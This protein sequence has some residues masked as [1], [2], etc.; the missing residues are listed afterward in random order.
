M[1]P[2]FDRIV[3]EVLALPPEARAVLMDRLR[4]TLPT[5]LDPEVER[6]WEEEIAR[7]VADLDAGR[8][9]TIPWQE[10]K[11]RLAGS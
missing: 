6:A 4:E 11:R 5:F 10:V 3:R 1:Q 8:T 2:D 7:R 9:T